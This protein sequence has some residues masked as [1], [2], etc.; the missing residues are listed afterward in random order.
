MVQNKVNDFQNIWVRSKDIFNRTFRRSLTPSSLMY[1]TSV[2]DI[3]CELIVVLLTQHS[4]KPSQRFQTFTSLLHQNFFSFFEVKSQEFARVQSWLIPWVTD[5]VALKM[6]AS[7]SWLRFP[8]IKSR[9]HLQTI[10]Y[11]K[12]KGGPPRLVTRGL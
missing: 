10:H 2:K 5:T 9:F 12:V 11:N 8:F 4:R 3:K 6:A 1:L 7:N